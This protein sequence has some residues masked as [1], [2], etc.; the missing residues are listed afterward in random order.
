M[1]SLDPGLP[2]SVPC[3]GSPCA[4]RLESM[5]TCTMHPFLTLVIQKQGEPWETT[6]VSV[7]RDPYS[8]PNHLLIDLE[9]I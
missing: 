3:F 5:L 1:T 9:T 2:I 8:G 7:M 4:P 6:Q